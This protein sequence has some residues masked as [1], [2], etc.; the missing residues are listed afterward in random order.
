MCIKI[1]LQLNSCV[2]CV[3]QNDCLL[4]VKYLMKYFLKS[5]S[6]NLLEPSGPVMGLLYLC[7][8]QIFI[9]YNEGRLSSV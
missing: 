1:V 7:L 6:L 3:C 5:E 9:L 4:F 8:Y 2:V